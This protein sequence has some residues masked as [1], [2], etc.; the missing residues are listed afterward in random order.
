MPQPAPLTY[1][2]SVTELKLMYLDTPTLLI[3][4]TI[5]VISLAIAL[6]F[7]LMRLRSERNQRIHL[8]AKE[9][10][11]AEEI[12]TIISTCERLRTERNQQ[13]EKNNT[14]GAELAVL[15]ST[16]SERDEQI[17]ARNELLEVTRQEMEKNFQILAEKIFTD[18][19]T[20]I[21]KKHKEELHTLLQP[22]REQL[23]EFK[24]RIEDVYDKETRDRVSLRKEIEHLKELNQQISTDAVNLTN[25]LKGQSKVQ[26]I[27]GEMI[28]ANLLENSGLKEGYEF[29]LQVQLKD[30]KGQTRIPDVLVHLPD[31][32]EIIVDAKV[33]LTAFERMARAEDPEDEKQLLGQHID[34]I[35]QHIRTLADKQYHLLEGINS[36]D[37]TVLFV[38]TEGAFQTAV[39]NDPELLNMAMQKKIILA[40]PST[41]LAILRTIHHLWRQEEQ[42]KNSL[43][44]AK[45]AGNLYDKFIGFLESFE[46]IGTRLQQ[47]ESAWETARNRLVSGRGNLVTRAESLKQLGVQTNKSLPSSIPVDPGDED[48]S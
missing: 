21:T 8:D 23:G 18:K 36:L 34:S 11:H 19:G 31:N 26:G 3:L 14:L 13:Q 47:T 5:G 12:S 48:E 16:L 22:V 44:I 1:D 32:R 6:V 41:L 38:P 2:S 35:K 7:C 33:S 28:L 30:R 24:K 27:W 25:A 40:S 17:A 43:I 42:T 4:T 10:I 45:Q 29:E 46:E 15:K 37:F 20:A 39:R 9:E